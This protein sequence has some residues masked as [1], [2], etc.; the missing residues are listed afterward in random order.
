MSISSKIAE[1]RASLPQGVTLVAVSKFHPVE[2]LKE[3]YD[4][5]QR[6]FGESRVQELLVKYESLPKDVEWHM[7]GHLQT[8]KV[9]SIAPFVA[10]VQSVDS[11]RLLRLIDREAARCGRVIDVLLEVHVAEEQTKSG[12]APEELLEFVRSGALEA[13]PNVRVRGIMGM[14]TNTDDESVIRSNFEQ[15]FNIK[16]VLSPHFDSSFDT[17]SMG[18]SDDYLLAV[19]CGSTM[20]RVGS[21]IFGNRKSF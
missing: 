19:S 9:R 21:K 7:I 18:M 14:A 13:M 2:A 11:E 15:L 4:A 8:N 10:L 12:W 20:V 17:L 6:I 5:G 1:L 3:A 16:K